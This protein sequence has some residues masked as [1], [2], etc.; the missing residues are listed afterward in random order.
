MK[1]YQKTS[2]YGLDWLSENAMG[3]NPLWLLED[4]CEHLDL[5]SGMK[6]L[7]MGCGKACTSVFLAKEFGVTVFAVDR[8]IDPTENLR[9]FE[10]MG[11]A[12]KVYP[13]RADA[14]A[15]PFA[16]DFFDAAVSVDSYHYYGTCELYFQRSFSKLVKGGGQFG[17][18]VPGY[19][20]EFESGHPV[21]GSFL[22]EGEFSFHSSEWWRAHWEKT[23]L[24]DI[25]TCYDVEDSHGVWSSGYGD[26]AWPEFTNADTEKDIAFIAMAAIKKGDEK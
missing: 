20:K 25:I 5:R 6:V 24:I 11:V 3:P 21:L 9:R 12:D 18:V 8:Y 7:D 23:K 14:H 15:L 19:T 1:N 26:L 22:G 17:I 4:I 13:I 2:K 16:H 10:A